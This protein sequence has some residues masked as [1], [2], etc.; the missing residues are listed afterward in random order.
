MNLKMFTNFRNASMLSM[1]AL[2]FCILVLCSSKLS[3]QM[4]LISGTSFDPIVA[5]DTSRAFWGINDIKYTGIQGG[6]L[7]IIPPITPNVNANIFD[8]TYYYAI[9]NNAYK[10]DNTRYNRTIGVASDNQLV[11]SPYR[12]TQ[13]NEHLLT[14][15][16]AGLTPG[17]NVEVRITYCSPIS[18]SYATCTGSGGVGMKGVLNPDTDQNSYNGGDANKVNPGTCGTVTYS[19]TTGQ[20]NPITAAGTMNFY[21]NTLEK[22]NC[23]AVAIK[24]IEVWGTP[25]PKV[26]IAEGSDV[27]AQEL[28][29]M[30]TATSYN[31]TYQWQVNT[32]SG[33]TNLST[34]PTASYT[35]ATAGTYQFRVSVTPSVGGGGP[36]TSDPVSVTAALC[37]TENGKPTSKKTIYYDDFGTLD[38]SDATGKTYQV[39][40]YSDMLNPYLETKTTT[41]PY[42]W[43]LAPAPTGATFVGTQ[44]TPLQDGQ[45]TV[46]SWIT[47]YNSYNGRTG[48]R[49]QWASCVTGPSSC[50]DINFDHSG[51]PEGAAL[52]LNFPASTGGQT[53]YTRTIDNLCQKE[54]TFEA[55]IAVFTNSAAGTYNPVDVK[56]RLTE[57]GNAANSVVANATATRAADGGGVWVKVTQKITL[58]TGTAITMDLINNQ[59]VS[60]NGNDLVLDDIK[61]TACAPPTIDAYFD[62]PTLAQTLSVCPTEDVPLYTIASDLLKNYYSNNQQYLFQ[63]TKTPSNIASWKNIGSPSA[64]PSNLSITNISGLT[65]VT[66]G[67]KIYFRVIAALPTTYTSRSNFQGGT[68]NYANYN[69]PCKIYSVSEPIE[70]TIACTLPVHLIYFTGQ[71]Q[72]TSNLIQWTTA[73]ERDNL[74]FVLE[75]SAD[76]VIFEDID[77]QIGKT[78]SN[79]LKNYFFV[80]R[81]PL[82]GGNYYR[83]RQVDYSGVVTYSSTLFLKNDSESIGFGLY[84]NP[85][86]GSFTIEVSDWE[87][88]T[89]LEIVDI[90]GRT[91]F[92]TSNVSENGKIEI[93]GLTEGF[94][95]VKLYQLSQVSTQKVVI[96]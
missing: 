79:G 73:R 18:T 81:L 69:D 52:F 75:R 10:L 38:L 25:K 82:N 46:A 80:D 59:N 44:D 6:N 43:T 63:W 21:L 50:P 29:T 8:A 91:L 4:V 68:A 90:N 27:C 15:S 77:Q 74:Y 42:R 30:S 56:V 85:N 95:F 28:I 14:Y 57:V 65:T 9:T 72:G 41:T 71:Q 1:K 12:G 86:K 84:P 83:L 54:L 16:V 48:A 5:T 7:T 78:N 96:Y 11:I 51:K 20:S 24:S 3:A 17:A 88:G 36:F 22:G 39:W 61:I 33:W 35:P 76:G 62:V 53:F 49:L 40:N 87:L 45:Y 19:T 55:W 93:N 37:C 64:T 70:A 58:T 94:Y 26:L 23:K 92:H 89:Y 34:N 60:V 47:G 31:G 32:G 13:N 66:T 67:D 2:C